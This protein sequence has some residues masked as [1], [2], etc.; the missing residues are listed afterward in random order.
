MAPVPPQSTW[1]TSTSGSVNKV[2]RSSA[3]FS[4]GPAS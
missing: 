3:R 4:A 1:I 2:W